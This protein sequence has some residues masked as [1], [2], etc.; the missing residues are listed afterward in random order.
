MN[1]FR[2]RFCYSDQIFKPVELIISVKMASAKQYTELCPAHFKDEMCLRG[3]TCTFAH[4]AP[5]PNAKN[6][7]MSYCPKFFNGTC[8][9]N[10]L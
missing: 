6:W 4:E 7:K 2:A 1:L 9:R 10:D 5:P 3:K 8:E